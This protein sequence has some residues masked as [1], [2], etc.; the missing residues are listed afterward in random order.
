MTFTLLGN[1]IEG[2]SKVACQAMEDGHR[3]LDNTLD[4][5]GLSAFIP[6]ALHEASDGVQGIIKRGVG[7]V[8]RTSGTVLRSFECA[9]PVA[10][11]SSSDD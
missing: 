4:A 8:G 9:V 3:T 1:L 7:D 10:S 2:T 11:S 5:T 6:P